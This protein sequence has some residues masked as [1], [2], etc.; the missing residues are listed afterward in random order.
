MFTQNLDADLLLQIYKKGLLSSA[1]KF[2]PGEEDHW[3]LQEDNDP[4]HTSKK[5][6][7]W[8]EENQVTRMTWPSQ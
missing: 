5:A 6:K 8:K 3:I 7:K 1:K 4:K 2:F